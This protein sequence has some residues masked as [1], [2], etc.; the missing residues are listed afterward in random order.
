MRLENQPVEA[1]TPLDAAA[2][3]KRLAAEI[4][5]HDV[6]YHRFDAPIVSDAEYDALCR[7]N[8]AIE[9]RFPHLV[10]PD[11]PSRRLGAP[12]MAGFAKVSHAVPMLSL[13]N[14][15]EAGD[16]RE[17]V[18][19]VRRFLKELR[20]DPSLPLEFV[21][22]P[23]ID[24]LSVSLRYEKGLFVQG[25]TRGDGREGEDVT[26]NLRTLADLP[27]TL[28]GQAPEVLEV[29][30]E[31]YMRRADFALLNEAQQAA[32]DKRFANPRNAAAGSLRQLDPS[33]T[34][35]RPLR[36]FAYAWGE[37]SEPLGTTQW[38]ARLRLGALGF[39][40]D[41]PARRCRNID[42]MLAF[43]AELMADRARLPFDMDGVVYKV[44][45]LDWQE[46]LGAAGRAPRWAV[47]HKFPAEQ[48]ATRL[49]AIGI[50]VGRTGA[51]TPV[52]ELEPVTVGGVV[53]SRATLHNED[54][55]AR[56]D[57]RAGDTVM[58]QR[59]GDVIPQ[60]VSVVLEQRPAGSVP[61]VFPDHCPECGSLALREEGGAVRRCTGGLVC[62]AQA[63]ERLKHFVSRDAFD[64]EGLGGK[65]VEAFWQDGLI[66]APADI[67]RLGRRREAIAAREGWGEKSANNLVA[68][69]E[70]RRAIPLTRFIFAL[71]I[72]QVG[73]ATAR[74]LARHYGSLRSWQAAMEA[75]SRPESEAFRD[76][77]AIDGVGPSLAGDIAAFFAES[78]NREVLADLLG[79]VVVED[80]EVPAE[81]VS[82]V[83][84]RTVVFT[85]TLETLTR[86]EAKA[87]AEALGAKVAGSVSRKTDY[88][89]AGADAGSKARKAEELGVTVLT[90]A[91]W[92]ALCEQD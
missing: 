75:A 2:E 42:E 17:F 63:V 36:L 59:A 47:A 73:V 33:V 39:P 70:S 8:R 40:L 27:R 82:P 6:A 69:L 32:G 20:D 87:R 55:I 65:H 45:R 61:F 67:F 56:K 37:A 88:L 49:R 13:G 84:G 24:G 53:V 15:F 28:V 52:A 71:G 5:R 4:A 57:V 58:V 35:A 92:L 26:A 48:A 14:A 90:E 3:L 25:A 50:Q 30:G 91:E 81:T 68:A 29:R 79:E 1:L 12:G 76:L 41:E 86:N 7:R 16:V 66:A 77:V 34:A 46:R 64:I 83:A 23:K 22:E 31:V 43:H 19:G 80:H 85:G 38:E 18:A 9:E 10:R 51:L 60:V 21:A 72:R 54:E 11:S 44:D 89:V 78:H 74:L 62:P